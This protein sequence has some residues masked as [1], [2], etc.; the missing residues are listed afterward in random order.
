MGLSGAFNPLY[1][2]GADAMMADL[3]EPE[4][5][6]DA[7]SLL[8]TSNNLGVAIGPAV[9]GVIASSSYSIAFYIAA[10]GM[11]L[12]SLLV[13]MFAVETLPAEA[14]QLDEPKERFAGYDKVLRDRQFISFIGTI[15]LTQVAAAMIW[16]LLSV[17]AKEN[18]GVPESLYGLIPT[19]NALM[20]VFLQYSTT[21][22]TKRYPPL[23]A[24]ASG[25]LLYGLAIGSIALGRGFWGFWL[26]MVVLTFGEL[27][28][29]PTATTLAANLAPA[30]MRGRYMSIYGLTWAA[31]TGIGPVVGG[32]LNDMI[33]P[34]AIWIG[35]GLIGLAGSAGFLVLFRVSRKAVQDRARANPRIL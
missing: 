10:A 24:L 34:T 1:R 33:S 32:L 20:V 28:M 5:R 17:Y 23:L 21:Q 35:G 22:I 11:L 16:I 27:I 29:S 18:Y 8:R 30:T 2:V 31:A 7:Y 15:T 25:S 6:V 19:T 12:Y 4:K 26:S 13:S 9:G 3:I 14:R